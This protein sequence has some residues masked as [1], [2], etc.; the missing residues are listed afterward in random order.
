MKKTRE[1]VKAATLGDVPDDFDAHARAHRA[2]QEAHAA[3][4]AKVPPAPPLAVPPL[5]DDD[6]KTTPRKKSKP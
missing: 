3:E 1:M 2:A 4:R 6:A 5:P